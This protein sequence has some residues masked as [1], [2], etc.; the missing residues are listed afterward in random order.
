MKAK[1]LLLAGLAGLA[2]ATYANEIVQLRPT[3]I[4]IE[5]VAAPPTSHVGTKSAMCTASANPASGKA[6]QMVTAGGYVS[7]VITNNTTI[8]QNYWVDEYMCINGVGC[9][10]IRNTV[11]LN[12]HLSGNGGGAIATQQYIANKGNYVDQASIQ[13]T[14]ESTCF[15]QGSNTV[16][17]S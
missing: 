15:V 12:P 16:S 9:T 1:V 3:P 14:G 7:Y 13:V 4:L 11:T 8:A 17:V 6:G 2:G 5:R 10:H